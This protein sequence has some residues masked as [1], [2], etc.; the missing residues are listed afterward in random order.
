M[1]IRQKFGWISLILGVVFVL[2]LELIKPVQG[3]PTDNSAIVILFAWLFLSAIKKIL[4]IIDEDWPVVTVLMVI[5]LGL[6]AG[7]LTGNQDVITQN[8]FGFGI[9][10][11]WVIVDILD[12]VLGD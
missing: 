9:C 7:V 10:V 8:I 4:M 12:S 1:T 2:T 6:L 3:F 11:F 5:F